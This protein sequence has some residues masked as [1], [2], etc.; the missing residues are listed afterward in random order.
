MKVGVPETDAIQKC[1]FKKKKNWYTKYYERIFF[2]IF[3]LF[4]NALWYVCL[5][6]NYVTLFHDLSNVGAIKHNTKIGHT[7]NRELIENIEI[8]SH[9]QNF[10]H[11]NILDL[12]IFPHCVHRWWLYIHQSPKQWFAKKY[13]FSW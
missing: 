13:L 11:P 2:N 12:L 7:K 3:C 5:T 6:S 10:V 1:K 9:N 4:A 8:A